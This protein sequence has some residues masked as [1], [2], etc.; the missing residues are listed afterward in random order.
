[1]GTKRGRDEGWIE[2]QDAFDKIL[3]DL[4]AVKSTQEGTTFTGPT[5]GEAT[6]PSNKTLVDSAVAAKKIV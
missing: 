2:H 3:A 5:A 1:M 6:P 4:N